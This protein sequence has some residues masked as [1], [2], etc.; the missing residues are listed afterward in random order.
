MHCLFGVCWSG[1]LRSLSLEIT[2]YLAGQGPE[3]L[4]LTLR[5][6]MVQMCGRGWGKLEITRS[7]SLT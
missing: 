7:A 5:L 6:V 2:Q 1:V 4:D 3:Q